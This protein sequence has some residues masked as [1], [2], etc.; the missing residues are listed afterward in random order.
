MK[1]E[2]EFSSR[3]QRFKAPTPLNSP[4]RSTPCTLNLSS[5]VHGIQQQLNAAVTPSSKEA[6]RI[7]QVDLSHPPDPFFGLFNP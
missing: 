7:R 6:S 4:G 3:L 5:F 2:G 1:G